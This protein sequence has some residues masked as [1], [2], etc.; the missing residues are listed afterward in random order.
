MT[1]SPGVTAGHSLHDMTLK[2]LLGAALLSLTL[3]GCDSIGGDD[4]IQGVWAA[5]DIE[6]DDDFGTYLR[7]TEATLTIANVYQPIE[8]TRG[9]SDEIGLTSTDETVF[10]FGGGSDAYRVTLDGDD[11]IATRGS[12]TRRYERSRLNVEDAEDCDDVV[13]QIR[14]S[15]ASTNRAN[16]FTASVNGESSYQA[17]SYTSYNQTDDCYRSS[18][19]LSVTR[20]NGRTFTYRDRDGDSG[21]TSAFTVSSDGRSLSA[22]DNV[23]LNTLT[24]D[25]DIRICRN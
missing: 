22:P 4:G 25:R 23:T 2:T 10:T 24:G 9:D 17:R 6:E 1:L 14:G 15:W 5:A 12:S 3:F 21:R 13:E 20:V 7:I 11:L 16:A 18:T 19:S 8:C